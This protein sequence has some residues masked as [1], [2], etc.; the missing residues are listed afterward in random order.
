MKL[1]RLSHILTIVVCC[2]ALFILVESRF[3]R[4]AIQAPSPQQP[5]LV[6]RPMNLPDVDWRLSPITVVL[7]INT[8]CHFCNES[9]PFYRNLVSARHR[10]G[11][12]FTLVILSSETASMLQ[13]YLAEA[14]IA[15]DSVLHAQ[16]PGLRSTP[17]ILLVDSTGTIRRAFVGKLSP[18]GEQEVLSILKRGII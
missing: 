5:D 11:S 18:A 15:A 12:R 6:G 4:P 1:E 9:M 17:T 8:T 3:R 16:V 2:V 10:D 7:A 13:Q 14:Q